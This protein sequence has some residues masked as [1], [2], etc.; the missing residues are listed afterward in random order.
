MK[1]KCIK[2]SKSVVKHASFGSSKFQMGE[3]FSTKSECR[4]YV[5]S[6]N[7]PYLRYSLKMG[8]VLPHLKLGATK[9]FTPMAFLCT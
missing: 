6:L 7:A 9:S 5:T 1:I 3:N 4:R 2:F 8:I